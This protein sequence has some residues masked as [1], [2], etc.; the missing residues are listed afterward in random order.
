MPGCA[1]PNQ[2]ALNRWAATDLWD[3]LASDTGSKGW[4]KE[5]KVG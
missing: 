5:G 3:P 1:P 4:G 2:A